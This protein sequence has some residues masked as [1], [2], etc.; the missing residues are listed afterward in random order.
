VA[1]AALAGAGL[2]TDA[3]Y[4]R[5]AVFRA[6]EGLIDLLHF[7]GASDEAREPARAGDIEARAQPPDAFELVDLHRVA[8]ALDLAEV[9]QI[10]VFGDE[11]SGIGRDVALVGC[12]ELLHPGSEADRVALRSPVHAQ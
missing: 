1:E 6:Q 8:D 2:G 7:V 9:P 10:E 5:V 3:D 4:A 12:G 11:R